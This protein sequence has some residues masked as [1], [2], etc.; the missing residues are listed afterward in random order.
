[1]GY[2]IIEAIYGDE[3]VFYA[4]VC[5]LIHN[6][7]TFSYAVSLLTR[8]A[9]TES[10]DA[11][12]ALASLQRLR[13]SHCFFFPSSYPQPYIRRW[14]GLAASPFRFVCSAPAHA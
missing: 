11:P 6:L 13:A 14:T 9:D 12:Q 5:N 8:G 7:I 4:S 3:G 2:P 1:M 10:P